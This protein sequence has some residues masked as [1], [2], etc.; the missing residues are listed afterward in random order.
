MSNLWSILAAVVVLLLLIPVGLVAVIVTAVLATLALISPLL[1]L[2]FLIYILVLVRPNRRKATDDRLLCPY[3]HR[4]FHG[5]GVPENSMEAFR[6]ACEAG[7]GIELD[8]QTT[9]DGVVVV[10]HDYH[11]SHMTGKDALLSELTLSE[12]KALRLAG[13]DETIPTLEEVLTLVDGRVP[14]LV[15]LKGEDTNTALC[16]PAAAILGAYRGP[17]C[18]ESFNPLMVREMGKLLPNVWRGLLYTNVF[19][20]KNEHPFVNFLLVCMA[21]NFLCKPDFIAFNKLDRRSVAVWLATRLYSAPRFVWTVKTPEEAR[22][23]AERGEYPIFEGVT[24]SP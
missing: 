9:R 19:R 16:A 4:G 6:L 12:L 13:T 17:Y 3:A 8:V 2:L 1:L 22:E 5:D 11:L 7:Y 14:L 10:F 15:E 23:A 24:P 20:G 21:V 18:V